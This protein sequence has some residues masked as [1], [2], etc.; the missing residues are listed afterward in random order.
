MGASGER[1]DE[2]LGV[3][4]VGGDEEIAAALLDGLID[5]A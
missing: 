4:V 1:V 2:H 5:A 3:A